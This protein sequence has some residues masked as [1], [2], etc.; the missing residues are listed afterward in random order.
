MGMDNGKQAVARLVVAVP[1]SRQAS[2]DFGR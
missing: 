2:R 1:P